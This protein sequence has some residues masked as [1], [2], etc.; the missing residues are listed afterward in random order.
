MKTLMTLQDLLEDDEDEDVED[1]DSGV[2]GDSP[3]PTPSTIVT[4]SGFSVSGK[5]E[6]NFN[7]QKVCLVENK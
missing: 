3:P 6:E 2:G 1:V 7:H 5:K 4:T